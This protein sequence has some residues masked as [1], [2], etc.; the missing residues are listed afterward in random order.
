M[1]VLTRARLPRRTRTSSSTSPWQQE[2]K[3]NDIFF[4]HLDLEAVLVRFVASIV[5]PAEHERSVS[6]AL[7][8]GRLTF[9]VWR[10]AGA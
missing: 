3:L 10:L 8:G 6:A 9:G 7:V 2:Q 1:L 5:P 4:H